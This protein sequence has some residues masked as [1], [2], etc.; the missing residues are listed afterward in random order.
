M[1]GFLSFFIDTDKTQ[2]MVFHQRFLLYE[3]KSHGLCLRC[4]SDL[5]IG[6]YSQI[7]KLGWVESIFFGKDMFK[8]KTL[9][10]H[11]CIVGVGEFHG[12][13]L[14]RVEC[15]AIQ[16]N[17]SNT[18]TEGTEQS[19]RIREVSAVERSWILSHFKGSIDGIK[20]PLRQNWPKQVF[21]VHLN[22][23]MD[24]KNHYNTSCTIPKTYGKL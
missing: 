17:L 3:I 15:F 1:S 5:K 6:F 21:E 19:V 24:S 22:C 18:D 10:F 7:L 16:S 8:I 13:Y 14:E 23:L 4:V 20:C 12:V 11:R 2:T 9:I